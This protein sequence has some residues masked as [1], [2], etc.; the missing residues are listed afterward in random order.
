MYHVLDNIKDIK[1]ICFLIQ[2]YICCCCTL[3]KI[4]HTQENIIF[5]SIDAIF[6]EGLFSK[7]TNS[8]TKEYK[9]YNEVLNKIS[10]ETELLVSDSFRKDK[11]ALVPISHISIP[12]IQNNTS[13]YSL[14][15]FP[16][17]KSASFPFTSGSRKPIVEIEET[18]NIDSDIEMQ[19][20]S[21]QQPLQPIL[22]T[23][24]EGSKLRR[25]KHQTQIL[26]REEN[27]YG[28]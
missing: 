4:C 20:S 9:L 2:K 17:Y 13:T 16:F 12:P 26:L 14:L 8:Y 28:E 15:S 18:N 3:G 25:S 5:H 11:P 19:L 6:D 27:I 24:Q 1:K 21:S 23:L 10:L 7:Y 22:Q